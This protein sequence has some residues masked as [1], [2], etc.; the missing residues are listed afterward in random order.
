M[1]R[2]FPIIGQSN[3]VGTAPL[4]EIQYTNNRLFCFSN[5][6][7]LIQGPFEPIDDP[8]DQIDEVS[9]DDNAAFGFAL[10]FA[11]KFRQTA[12]GDVGLIP[13]AKT[14]SGI[15]E[16]AYNL[17]RDSLYG[18]ALARCQYVQENYDGDIS[19]IVFWQGE[20]DTYTQELADSW[21]MK[22]AAF[23]RQFS[24]SLG[25]E[26]ELPMVYV[27]IAEGNNNAP[28]HLFWDYLRDERQTV[29]ANR[30]GMRM[31]VS[32][33]LDT[34]DGIH[35]V[36]ASHTIIGNRVANGMLDLLGLL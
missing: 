34:S 29:L 22:V 16:W 15:D 9:R 6:W 18:S 26:E 7:Q 19:G 14:G 24:R 25:F 13:C 11:R 28:P 8:T 23:R 21:P 35:M 3:A 2:W 20:R 1:F 12:G 33:D 17:S 5:A 31:I 4:P 30:P 32:K 10:Q 27:Q 36:T